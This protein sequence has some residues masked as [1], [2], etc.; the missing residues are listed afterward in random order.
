MCLPQTQR[1]GPEDSH[2]FALCG[3]YFTVRTGNYSPATCLAGPTPIVGLVPR[4]LFFKW[5]A[6]GFQDVQFVGKRVPVRRS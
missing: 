1:K 6:A 4:S 2:E 3:L 5:I